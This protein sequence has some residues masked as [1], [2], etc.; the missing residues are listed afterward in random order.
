MKTRNLT[1]LLTDIQG[2]TD[3]TAHQSRTQMMDMLKK[4]ESIVLPVVEEYKGRLIKTIGDAFLVTFLSP[5]D[6]VLCGV[7]IQDRLFEYNQ[8]KS[9]EDRIDV[10]IAINSGEVSVTDNDIFGDAVNITSRLESIAEAGQVFFTES[11]YLAMNKREVPSSEVGYRT[12]KGIPEQIKVYKVLRETPIGGGSFEDSGGEKPMEGEPAPVSP[13]ALEIKVD[14]SVVS[15][16]E[17]IKIDRSGLQAGQNKITSPLAHDTDTEI[18]NGPRAGLLRRFAALLLDLAICAILCS[19]LFGGMC[20]GG[21][22]RQWKPKAEAEAGYESDSDGEQNLNISL[23]DTD[24]VHDTADETTVDVEVQEEQVGDVARLIARKAH[25]NIV[26]APGVIGPTTLELEDV[27]WRKAM[28]MTLK[29]HGFAAGWIDEHTIM[30]GPPEQVADLK[31]L[32]AEEPGTGRVVEE[33][34]GD[35]IDLQ[36]EVETD[37]RMITA[38]RIISI[39]MEDIDIRSGLKMIAKQA[40][41]NIVIASEVKGAVSLHFQDKPLREVLNTT[42]PV[43]GYDYIWQDHETILV[44]TPQIIAS[45]KKSQKKEEIKD[46]IKQAIKH[47]IKHEAKTRIKKKLKRPNKRRGK[48]IISVLLWALYGAL[49]I[50]FQK[51][52]PGKKLLKM[53]VVRFPVC[54]PVGFWQA[55]ARSGLMWLSF[56]CALLGFLWAIWEEDKRAWHDLLAG[57]VVVMDRPDEQ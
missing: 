47:V 23:T 26:L 30:V 9:P 39:D 44:S 55:G 42:I 56:V 16:G 57:T 52:T 54:S 27:P 5:T 43:N 14:K 51:A 48:T 24:S 7:A 49:F 3:K 46:D 12:F 29:P 32:I 10:R 28:M 25:V 35:L 40:G 21:S 37:G 13:A 1:I 15:I 18:I 19:L 20:R 53:R 45:M 50:K 22:N 17:S 8:S 41:I 31:P 33:E 36:M 6:A 38:Q 4:H 2:F 34:Q 11:V